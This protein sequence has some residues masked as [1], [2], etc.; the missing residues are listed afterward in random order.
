MRARDQLLGVVASAGH[1]VARRGGR[2]GA[3]D[4]RLVQWGTAQELEVCT[5][6]R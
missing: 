3:S 1:V 6:Y 2:R 5:G 4:V